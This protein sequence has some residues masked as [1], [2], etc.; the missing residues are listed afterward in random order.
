MQASELRGC[1]FDIQR[2][3]VH[4]GSG[5][6]TCVFFK[7]CPL[8][9]SWCQNPEGMAAENELIWLDRSCIRC[10]T[11]TG[12]SLE[13]GLAWQ[14]ERLQ[15]CSHADED[16]D[17]I[18]NACPSGALHWSGTE[19]TVEE[20]MNVI[21]RDLPFYRHGGGGVTLTGGDPVLQADFS[22]ALLHQCCAE[23]IS[24]AIETE[25]ALP[26]DR[27]T[28]LLDLAD[29]LYVDLKLLDADESR[30]HTGQDNTVPLDN[31]SRLLTGV[32]RDKVVVRT[33]L[34]PGITATENNLRAAS[35]FLASLFP[36]VPWQLLNYNTL[37]PAKYQLLGK[38][39]PFA[40][41]LPAFTS[42]EMEAFA[43]TA[44]SGGMRR[45]F[46]VQGE[47]A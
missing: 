1:I 36:D 42:A 34:I 9:C 33:P 30:R 2:F 28:P 26:W 8:R 3:S 44:R 29:A 31:L 20:V 24:T 12:L 25:A 35:A 45:V 16:W 6:R 7:G 39:Y 41:D 10:G 4:D 40:M 37:A 38:Q 14:E 13:G 46:W 15:I 17:G 19:Y 47:S 5:I 21:R 32:H 23:H 18:T 22:E 27:M 11:C 43:A